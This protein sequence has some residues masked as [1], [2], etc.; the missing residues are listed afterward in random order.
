MR[1]LALALLAAC[2][3][4]APATA[5]ATATATARVASDPSCPVTV[6]GTSVAV[7]DTAT[8]AALVFV[9]TGDVA[10]MRQ[11]VVA[12]AAMHVHRDGPRAAMGM[13]IETPSMAT[14]L[15][16]PGGARV[17][18]DASP[19]DVAPLQAELHAH[20]EHLAS[21]TCRMGM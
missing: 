19:D 16:I 11:R 13:M 15:D 7:E 5:P 6:P 18:F 21:G 1:K 20:A 4:A 14:V 8:G 12:L 9:T 3:S 17:A 10:A 2:G